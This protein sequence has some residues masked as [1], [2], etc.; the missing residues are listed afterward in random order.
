MK[1]AKIRIGCNGCLTGGIED[2]LFGTLWQRSLL[3]QP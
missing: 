2:A 3:V 1:I